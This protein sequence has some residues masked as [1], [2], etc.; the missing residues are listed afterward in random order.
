MCVWLHV[1][2]LNGLPQALERAD[3][4]SLLTGLQA[5]DDLTRLNLSW[6]QGQARQTA[7]EVLS[8]PPL[9]DLSTCTHTHTHTHTV[10]QKQKHHHTQQTHTHN[11]THP[12][13]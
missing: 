9:T 6:P 8:K 12:H 1:C 2:Y 3:V 4:Q 10:R 7:P 11:H 13:T 5:G